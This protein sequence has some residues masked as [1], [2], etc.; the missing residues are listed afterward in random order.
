MCPAPQFHIHPCRILM[1]A[2]EEGLFH[3]LVYRRGNH[4]SEKMGHLARVT[5]L[6]SGRAG[7]PVPVEPWA[8]L[9]RRVYRGAYWKHSKLKITHACTCAHIRTHTHARMHSPD[10][11]S[12][13]AYLAPSQTPTRF[14]RS[15]VFK[16]IFRWSLLFKKLDI[17]ILVC[18]SHCASSPSPGGLPHLSS[19][20]PPWAVLTGLKPSIFGA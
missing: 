2:Y 17:E 3:S 4:G 13:Q 15:G 16:L 12:P 1:T 19:V 20:A 5:A 6:V 8:C 11:S 9:L 18:K 10:M 14:L 7:V